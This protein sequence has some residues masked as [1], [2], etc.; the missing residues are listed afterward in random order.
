MTLEL[1][2]L[3]GTTSDTFVLTD[4]SGHVLPGQRAVRT[5]SKP[6]TPTILTVEFFVGEHEGFVKAR[7]HKEST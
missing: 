7:L 6:R 2:R 1:R 4:D 3:K 5:E